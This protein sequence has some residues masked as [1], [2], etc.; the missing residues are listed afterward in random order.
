MWL[1][2]GSNFLA[3]NKLHGLDDPSFCNSFTAFL[4]EGHLGS[5]EQEN[6]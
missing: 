3:Y 4:V 2:A 5:P 6:P 1:M